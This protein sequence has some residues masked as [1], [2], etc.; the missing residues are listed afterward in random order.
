[1]LDNK[2][3]YIQKLICYYIENQLQWTNQIKVMFIYEYSGVNLWQSR[4]QL[5]WIAKEK[6]KFF[7]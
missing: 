5:V 7:S 4:R 3:F 2:G 6:I 1:M